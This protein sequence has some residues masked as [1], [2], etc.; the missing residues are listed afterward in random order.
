MGGVSPLYTRQMVDALGIHVR[1][2]R[3]SQELA[4][5]CSVGHQS[6]RICDRGTSTSALCALQVWSCHSNQKQLQGCRQRGKTVIDEMVRYARLPML[7][8]HDRFS[9]PECNGNPENHSCSITTILI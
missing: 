1:S 7:V 4:N 5:S 2:L 9:D 3:Q 6:T 8:D